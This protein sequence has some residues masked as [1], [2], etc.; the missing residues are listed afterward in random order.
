MKQSGLKSQIFIMLWDRSGYALPWKGAGRKKVE[1]MKQKNKFV[2]EWE[3]KAG[4][5]KALKAFQKM[6]EKAA[7]KKKRGG[8]R[9]GR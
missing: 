3:P 1:P 2:L 4:R 7:R 6:Q 5:G 8:K 9:H